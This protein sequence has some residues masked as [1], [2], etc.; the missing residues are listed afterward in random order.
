MRSKLIATTAIS[1]FIASTAIAQETTGAGA[2]PAMGGEM[3]NWEGPIGNA[4]FTDDTM[5]TPHPAEELQSNW[6]DLSEDEQEQVRNYCQ[7]IQADAGG[8]GA[9]ATGTDMTA[10][11]DA[12]ATEPMTGTDTTGA[13]T[14]ADTMGAGHQPQPQQMAEICDTVQTM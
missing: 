9:T 11:A 12:T 1:L 8:M 5:M 7:Q 3:M 6:Q 4:L 14:T 13:T 10:G 2:D